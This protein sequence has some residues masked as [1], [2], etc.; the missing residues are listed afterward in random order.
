MAK[1]GNNRA[2]I[3][4]GILVT[5]GVIGYFVYRRYSKKDELD[6]GSAP[7]PPVPGSQP[8]APVPSS[9]SSMTQ[10]PATPFKTALEGDTFRLFVN[11][12]HDE[13][14]KENNLDASGAY[15][16]AYARKA[17]YLFGNEYKMQVKPI[18]EK[19]KLAYTSYVPVSGN[20]TK[21]VIDIAA[22]RK[23]YPEYAWYPLP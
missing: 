13:W 5:L 14:A 16:N 17:W 4:G 23:K 10:Y 6:L 20:V 11:R 9:G 2:L 12:V 18:M 1:K 19:A 3:I 22:I 7:V 21:K 15:D 8:V